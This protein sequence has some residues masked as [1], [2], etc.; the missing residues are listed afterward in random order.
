MYWPHKT[1]W[2]VWPKCALR[3]GDEQFIHFATELRPKTL[4]KVTEK[5]FEGSLHFMCDQSLWPL[6]HIHTVK[7]SETY[8]VLQESSLALKVQE[9]V[10]DSA[11]GDSPYLPWLWEPK[12]TSRCDHHIPLPIPYCPLPSCNIWLNTTIWTDFGTKPWFHD[13]GQA[14]AVVWASISASAKWTYWSKCFVC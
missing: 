1:E 2:G 12:S 8:R 9:T 13:L 5:S 11:E 10:N 7:V 3:W 4:Q 14:P 6:R